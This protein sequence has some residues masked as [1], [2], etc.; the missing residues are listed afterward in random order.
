VFRC[1]VQY[2]LDSLSCSFTFISCLANTNFENNINIQNIPKIDLITVSSI[3]EATHLVFICSLD[4]RH[5]KLLISFLTKCRIL[6]LY[7]ME[8]SWSWSYGSW[9]YTLLCNQCLSPL[10][11]WVITPFLAT[12]NLYNIMWSSL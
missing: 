7:F 4:T 1:S 11:L 6:S 9:I 10:M 8:L 12:C 2:L 3:R 5:I